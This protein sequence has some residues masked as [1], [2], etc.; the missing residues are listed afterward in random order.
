MAQRVLLGCP[1]RLP[2]RT[3]G[4]SEAARF[5]AGPFRDPQPSGGFF[6]EFQNK[7]AS[8]YPFSQEGENSR[9]FQTDGFNLAFPPDGSVLPAG[10]AGRGGGEG[11]QSECSMSLECGSRQERPG[12]RLPGWPPR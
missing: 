4:L 3:V 9:S 8:Q 6:P 1:G 12:A 10:E 7:G 2:P 11:H 5:L